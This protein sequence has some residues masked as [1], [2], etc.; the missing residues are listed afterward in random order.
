MTATEMP[1][2]RQMLEQDTLDAG[3]IAASESALDH[4]PQAPPSKDRVHLNALGAARAQVAY[5][6]GVA[7]LLAEEEDVD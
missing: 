6:Q 2:L 4:G 1:T 3:R 7:D 5:W